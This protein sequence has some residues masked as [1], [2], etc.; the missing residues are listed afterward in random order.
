TVT[1]RAAVPLRQPLFAGYKLTR[2]VSVIKARHPGQ[3]TRGDVLRVTLTVDASAERNWVAV[4]DPVPAG[5]TILGDIGGQSKLLQQGEQHGGSSFGALIGGKA[6]E[7]D[8]GAQP[9]YVERGKDAW[10]GYWSWVPA[11]R[12]VTS[13]TLRL[14][15]AG[16]FSLPPSR[17]EAMYSPAVR[18][19]LPNAVVEVGER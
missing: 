6:Y 19:Q 4:T 5:A 8:V 18:A 15:G 10:R 3:L 17:V 9:A 13:Y 1:V 7:V 11:G 2:A 14:N 16:R 12:F